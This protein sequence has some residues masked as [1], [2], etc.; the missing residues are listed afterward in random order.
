ML[1]YVFK[2]I[3]FSILF[4]KKNCLIKLPFFYKAS[5]LFNAKFLWCIFVPYTTLFNR[6]GRFIDTIFTNRDFMSTK[7]YSAN[8][9]FKFSFSCHYWMNNEFIPRHFLCT[10]KLWNFVDKIITMSLW[11]LPNSPASTTPQ[12]IHKSTL[13]MTK[14]QVMHGHAL[15]VHDGIYW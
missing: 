11:M 8:L 14:Q 2:Y 13:K 1:L 15:T 3:L 9:F 4:Y 6:E 7:C 10:L 12:R 5:L